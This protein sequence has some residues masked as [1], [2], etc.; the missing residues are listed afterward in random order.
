M[1]TA[2]VIFSQVTSHFKAKWMKTI[3][4]LVSLRVSEGQEFGWASVGTCFLFS[5]VW[6]LGWEN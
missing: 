4:T 3:I 2:S 6:S 5:D 1:L